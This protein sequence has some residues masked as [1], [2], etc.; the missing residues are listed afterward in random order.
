MKKDLQDKLFDSMLRAAFQEKVSTQEP[1]DVPPHEFSPEF[2]RKMQK[3]IR[4]MERQDWR[5]THRR[6][7]R[8]V[9]AM[10]ALVIVLGGTLVVKVDAVRVPFV[11]FV[12]SVGDGFSSVD[13]V[14]NQ[15]QPEV[16]EDMETFLPAYV[17]DGFQLSS[18]DSDNSFFM[19]SYTNEA[20]S[21]YSI[22]F[23][24]SARSS[25]LDTEDA[26]VEQREI[27]G[28]PAI[29]IRENEQTIVEW[30][31]DGHEYFITGTVPLEE[32]LHM[33]DSIEKYF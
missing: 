24:R 4:R 32:I 12:L 23:Y 5:Q 7:L 25:A 1:E 17:P 18:S 13:I 14:G 20:E 11:N 33:I 15:N 8:R 28:Y 16:P 27:N 22:L 9:A 6:K 29:V 26:D 3:L 30:F 2:E 19:V 31:P 10:F 21:Y